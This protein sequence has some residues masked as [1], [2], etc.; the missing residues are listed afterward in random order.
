MAKREKKTNFKIDVLTLFPSM[1]VGPITESLIGRAREAGLVEI[2][3][4][5]LREW[6]DD[7]RHFKVDDRPYGG[8]AGMVFRPEP[9]YRALKALGGTKKG[10]DRPW[11]IY[12]SPKGDRFTQPLAKKLSKKRHLVFLC[13]HYEGIDERV[14][15]WVDQEVSIGDYVLTGGEIPALALIDAVVRLVPGVVG[16]PASLVEESFSKNTLE[17]PQFTRPEVWRGK[18]V[19]EILLSGHH[20]NIKEW[21]KK[22]SINQTKIKRPDLMPEKIKI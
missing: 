4:H 19:P 17:Y 22:E 14:M 7:K 3:V 16:D 10:P 21:R 8:G 2:N 5:Q 15:S 13:G 6:S 12:L 18:S 1:F 20:R 9:I 11:V